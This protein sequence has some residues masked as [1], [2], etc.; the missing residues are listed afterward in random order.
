MLWKYTTAFVMNISAPVSAVSAKATHVHF[1]MSDASRWNERWVEASPSSRRSTM[2]IVPKT[3]ASPMTC[4]DSSSGKTNSESRI[5]TASRSAAATRASRR[6]STTASADGDQL[7]QTWSYAI[8]RPRTM[9]QT[10]I[11]N[12]RI[13]SALIDGLWTSVSS[14]CCS[15]RRS[16]V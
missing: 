5:W 11:R 2:A 12:V 4:A 8:R 9:M 6:T 10:Q 1:K 16:A 3:S 14:H 7:P 13:A 15:C